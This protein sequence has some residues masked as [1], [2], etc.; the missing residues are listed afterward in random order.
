MAQ[1]VP[2]VPRT[3]RRAGGRGAPRLEGA[4]LLFPGPQP[5]PDGADGARPPRWRAAGGSGRAQDAARDRGIHGRRRREHRLRQS[6]PGR[7]RQRPPRARPP[8]RPPPPHPRPTPP[9]GDPSARPR[10]PRRPQRGH[11]GAGRDRL[12]PAHAPLRRV[13]RRGLLRRAPGRHRC[14]APRPP[15]TPPHPASRLRD[16]R[17]PRPGRPRPA[18]KAPRNRPPRRHVGVPVGAPRAHARLTRRSTGLPGEHP[19]PAPARRHP[20]PRPHHPRPG[21]PRRPR[22]PRPRGS[23]PA[24]RPPRLH[25]PP[26]HLS[27]GRHALRPVRLRTPPPA[28]AHPPPASAHPMPATAWVHPSRL[29]EWALPVAQQKIGALLTAWIAGNRPR[30]SG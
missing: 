17:R 27:P 5:P 4:R 26:R 13:P 18:G 19:G 7:G 10:P 24:P 25:A 8:P 15:P 9:R 21:A 30:A 23:H 12:H 1:T 2:G 29:D 16:R 20:H 11:D 28:S 3:R 6:G 22:L 14:A